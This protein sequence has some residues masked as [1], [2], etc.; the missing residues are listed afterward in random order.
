[1]GSI[2]HLVQRNENTLLR[3]T[4]PS[5]SSQKKSKTISSN[6]RPTWPISTIPL[7]SPDKS[8]PFRQ[9]ENNIPF[10]IFLQI[11]KGSNR[12]ANLRQKRPPIEHIVRNL[13]QTVI[14]PRLPSFSF[15]FLS[16][17]LFST[18]SCG[19]GYF[20]ARSNTLSRWRDSKETIARTIERYKI[21]P[22]SHLSRERRNFSS[23]KT[24]RSSSALEALIY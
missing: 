7:L 14:S 22:H 15:L 20:C 5:A 23:Y 12:A 21:D 2:L 3:M 8:D 4:F 10:P 24:G 6:R 9:R 11:F 19:Q 17:F 13:R 1:M 18:F 16:L